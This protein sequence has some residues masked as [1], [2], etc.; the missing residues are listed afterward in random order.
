MRDVGM[1]ACLFM[2]TAGMVLGGFFIMAGRMFM[3]LNRFCVVDFPEV[4][5]R[6]R[7]ELRKPSLAKTRVI[8]HKLEYLI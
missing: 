6:S 1:M 2:A 4:E 8:F 7:E 5:T 3:V